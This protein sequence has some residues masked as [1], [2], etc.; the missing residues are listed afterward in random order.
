MAR[1]SENYRFINELTEEQFANN[2][3]AS[4]AAPSA[5]ETEGVLE[6][7]DQIVAAEHNKINTEALLVLGALAEVVGQ[8]E[9]NLSVF[10]L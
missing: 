9:R 6:R 5:A 10:Y 3:F 2:Q 8:A 1:Q 4:I 7:A